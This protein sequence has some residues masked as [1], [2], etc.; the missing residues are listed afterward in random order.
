[1]RRRR[2]L[3]FQR[4][5][6]WARVL[7][8]PVAEAIESAP[9]HISIVTGAAAMSLSGVGGVAPAASVPR[10]IA[11]VQETVA[12]AEYDRIPD[13]PRREFSRY[14]EPLRVVATTASEDVVRASLI[15]DWSAPRAGQPL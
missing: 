6:H 14:V 4:V 3:A 12:V 2:R 15:N 13:P 7:A 11:P 5:L 9:L 10:I 8:E 1:M